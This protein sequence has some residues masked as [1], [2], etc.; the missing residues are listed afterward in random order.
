[1]FSLIWAWINGWVNNR[2]A[3]D[4]RPHHTLYGTGRMAFWYRNHPQI[5]MSSK[6][7]DNCKTSRSNKLATFIF[8]C[9]MFCLSPEWFRFCQDTWQVIQTK[10]R[11]VMHT[12]IPPS[13]WGH[14]QELGGEVQELQVLN[15]WRPRQDGHLF[16]DDI[17]KLFSRMQKNELW[18]I[19][20]WSLFL[21]VQLTISKHWFR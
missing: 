20:H 5:Q 10:D 11:H 12:Y 14:T 6:S 16:A 18:L 1:M 9:N 15:T 17:Y 3:S 8:S 2:E 13:R 21:R 7:S 4:L 19:F